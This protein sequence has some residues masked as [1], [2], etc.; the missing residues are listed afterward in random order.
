MT[1]AELRGRLAVRIVKVGILLASVAGV[2][3][4]LLM[5]VGVFSLAVWWLS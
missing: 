1:A 2:V 4:V 5:A 3:W